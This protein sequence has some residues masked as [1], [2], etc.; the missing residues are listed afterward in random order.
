MTNLGGSRNFV[1]NTFSTKRH[2][3]P[4]EKRSAGKIDEWS[5]AVFCGDTLDPRI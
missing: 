2:L 3:S 5:I 1:K 4:Q